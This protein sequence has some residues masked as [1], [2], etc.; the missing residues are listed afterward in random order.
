[1]L[2]CGPSSWG[3]GLPCFGGPFSW[4]DG[5]PRFSVAPRVVVMD[6]HASVWP[7]ELAKWTPMLQ[8]SPLSWGDGLPCFGV[9]PRVGEMDS[10]ASV[11]HSVGEMESHASVWPLELGRWSPMLRCGPLSSG[12]GLPCFGVTPRFREMDSH[13]S[14]WPLEL[15]GL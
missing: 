10:H 3:D 13:P 4:G 14:V 8:C 5:V 1:M 15:G 9:A 11:A 2:R 6:S 7:R 12:D